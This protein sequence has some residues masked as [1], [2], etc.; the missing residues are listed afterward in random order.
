MNFN[1][2][3][4]KQKNQVMEGT[5]INSHLDKLNHFFSGSKEYRCYLRR[6]I[7]T[8]FYYVHY[9][10]PLKILSIESQMEEVYFYQRMCVIGREDQVKGLSAYGQS[11][12]GV[13]NKGKSGNKSKYK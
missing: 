12:K 8:S 7:K 10:I 13:S 11:N 6:E 5:Q 4:A 3:N 9:L 2:K 1:D